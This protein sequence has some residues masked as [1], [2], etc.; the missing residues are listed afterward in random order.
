M[1]SLQR[2]KKHYS[3]RPL[4]LIMVNVMEPEETVEKFI[5]GKGYDFTV[6]LDETGLV[7]GIYGVQSHPMTFIV[8]PSG[9]IVGLGLGYKEW[10]SEGVKAV[11]DRLIS[12]GPSASQN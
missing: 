5:D 10:D 4:K 7:S 11:I 1:P 3:G 8:A 6:L 9:E 2:L 12:Q